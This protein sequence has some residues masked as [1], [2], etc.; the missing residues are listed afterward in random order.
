MCYFA[1]VASPL[2]LS[3]VRSMLPAGIS[4]DLLPMSEQRVL[5][6]LFPDAQTV[7]RLL[8]GA[9]SCDLV[10]ER[11]ATAREDEAQLRRRYRESGVGRP[12]VLRAIERHRQ[13]RPTRRTASGQWP[14]ALVDFVAE[15]ARNAGPTLYYLQFSAE[16]TLA[17]AN[18]GAMGRLSLDDVRNHPTRWLTESRPVLVGR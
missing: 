10:R 3:E 9:C 12:L 15:H 1:Y 2:T 18:G 13:G 8:R 14:R 6:E 16:P 17:E 5:K 11:E 4:A 7:A